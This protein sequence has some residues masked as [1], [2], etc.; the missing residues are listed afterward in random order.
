MGAPVHHDS[1]SSL[2]KF[3][4]KATTL[5]NIAPKMS[6]TYFKGKLFSIEK[7]T[8]TITEAAIP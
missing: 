5:E 7:I 8:L 3:G 1:I 6:K 4:V 2:G